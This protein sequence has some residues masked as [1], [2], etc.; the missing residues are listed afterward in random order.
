MRTQ[1]RR[2]LWL[3]LLAPLVP[4][5]ARAGGE[6]T[7]NRAMGGGAVA[8]VADH[9]AIAVNPAGMGQFVRYSVG[10]LWMRE[11]DHWAL[12]VS[13]LD[14]QSSTLSMGLDYR[15][16]RPHSGRD[17]QPFHLTNELVL[18]VAEYYEGILHA[19]VNYRLSSWKFSPD[20]RL[21]YGHNFGAGLIVPAGEQWRFGAAVHDVVPI[22]PSFN[23]DPRAQIGVAA[24][25]FESILTF[26]LDGI[27][28]WD[29]G[30]LGEVWDVAAGIEAIALKELGLRLG[31]HYDIWRNE[32]TFSA[33]AGWFFPRG[34]MGYSYVR[35]PNGKPGHTISFEVVAF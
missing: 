17:N 32:F 9:S 16:R 29:Q 1:T 30:R 6:Y 7:Q 10:A 19:G 11:P 26:T 20:Q 35:F 5:T 22:W 31:G 4:L 33:G 14:S 18:G 25:A 28:H 15:W 24:A 21:S 8:A 3:A 23:H 13:V 12:G 34:H 2:A 27:W